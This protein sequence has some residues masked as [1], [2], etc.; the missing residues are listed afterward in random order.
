[1]IPTYSISRRV[2][3]C[4]RVLEAYD[5]DL[6]I[7]MGGVWWWNSRNRRRVE[8]RR[9]V[10]SR[11]AGGATVC[12]RQRCNF[13]ASLKQY[14]FI[15]SRRR[16]DLQTFQP[17][18]FF[19]FLFGNGTRGGDM[20]CSSVSTTVPATVAPCMPQ[21]AGINRCWHHARQTTTYLYKL[22]RLILDSLIYPIRFI[23][24]VAS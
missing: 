18:C 12:R 16:H 2:K 8:S 23:N 10:G 21:G 24:I 14:I 6:W 19:I 11:P 4:C 15:Y 20:S 17:I 9:G 5:V 7:G 3:H 13:H 22:G 1:L